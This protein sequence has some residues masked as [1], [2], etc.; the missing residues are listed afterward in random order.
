MNNNIGRRL[1]T[2]HLSI[3]AS[4]LIF[5]TVGVVR[6]FVLF[7]SGF[8]A[9]LRGF[10]G[11]LVIALFMLFTK[12][13]LNLLAIKS[14]ALRLILS[15]AFIGVNWIL[16]F[17]AFNYTSIA[18][19]TVCYYLAPIFV[20]IISPF[21]LGERIGAVRGSAVVLALVGAAVVS[22]PWNEGF[23]GGGDLVGVLLAVGAAV[24]Y[25]GVTVLNKKM[26]DI[27]PLD[28]TLVQLAVAAA[29]VLPYTLIAEPIQ[30]RM[31]EFTTVLLV[32][33]LG[34]VHTGVAYLFYFSAVNRLPAATS[35]IFSYI[36]PV[37]AV[38][39]SAIVLKEPFTVFSALGAL[40][41]LGATLVSELFGDIRKGKR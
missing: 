39:L 9:M 33:L 19:A 37:F 12:K 36:D 3:I 30:P 31:F 11:A 38:I 35:A 22:E 34:A 8:T 18:V 21:A 25:S 16:L 14:N 28:M 7:P 10:I 24:F 27:P 17:E 26:R 6:R 4:M 15:G 32:I 2:P 1:G 23:A 13:R 20:I 29:V 41:I 5:G 40:I